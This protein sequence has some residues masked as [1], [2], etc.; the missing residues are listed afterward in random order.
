MVKV[1]TEL[2]GK[3]Y[4]IEEGKPMRTLELHIVEENE[5]AHVDSHHY[6]QRHHDLNS[7]TTTIPFTEAY[8]GEEY[9]REEEAV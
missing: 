9:Q 8:V 6:Q 4:T 5:T 2:I 1:L 3:R 7:F